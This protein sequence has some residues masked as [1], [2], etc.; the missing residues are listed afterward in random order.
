MQ[1][2]PRRPSTLGPRKWHA[3]L[4]VGVVSLMVT[5]VAAQAKPLV[6][7]AIVRQVRPRWRVVLQAPA[8]IIVVS[9]NF[10]YVGSSTGTSGVTALSLNSG[11]TLWHVD[12]VGMALIAGHSVFTYAAG[13]RIVALNARTGRPVWQA[14]L[15]A[16]SDA[17]PTLYE[18]GTRLLSANGNDLRA[19]DSGTGKMLWRRTFDGLVSVTPL[20]STLVAASASPLDVEPHTEMFSV[21][22]ILDGSIRWSSPGDIAYCRAGYAYVRHRE[23]GVPDDYEAA[24]F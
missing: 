21:I 16:L 9:G 18:V 24:V 13:N 14:S 12:D 1:Q 22:N 5:G 3:R 4:L 7:T 8:P 17:E 11:N 10:A 23:I 20:S 6:Q 19:Y 2:M 15:P